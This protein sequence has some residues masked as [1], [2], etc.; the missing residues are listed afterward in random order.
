MTPST[1][2]VPEGTP[3]ARLD[4]YLVGTL[5][6]H[7]RNQIQKWIRSGHILVNG[8]DTEPSQELLGGEEIHVTIPA[9]QVSVVPEKISLDVL[10]EDRW[11]LAVNKPA[12]MVT[13]PAAKNYT[14]TL[15]NAAAYHLKKLSKGPRLRPG[16]VHRLD[17]ETS[18]ILV[19]AKDTQSL[20]ILSKQFEQR[21][22]EK[23]YRALVTGKL[24]Q[25]K[26]EIVGSIGKDFEKMR[27]TVSSAGRY[28]R[29]DY[30]IV[31][32]FK[33]ETYV[34]AYPKTGRTHQIRVHF[35]KIGHP[36]AGD[37]IYSEDASKFPRM[38]LH[39]YRLTFTHPKTKKRMTLEA[40]L[41]KDFLKV[42]VVRS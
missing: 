31:K 19:L 29:T 38:M 12:G 3:P 42:M 7:S 16:L 26:G 20:N 14:G 4:Q 1:F 33:T 34:E 23:V 8:K 36:V 35:A 15:L 17:K 27:M 2:L 30:K 5:E 6:G 21:E 28:A 41:P 10:Y 24:E 22:V 32:S 18:G 9:E 39:A 11:I 13:H 40:P 37:P 25:K